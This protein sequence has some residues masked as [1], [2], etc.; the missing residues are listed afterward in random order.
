[1]GETMTE[2]AI[3]VYVRKD[4]EDRLAALKAG[5]SEIIEIFD[6]FVLA[7]ATEEEIEWCKRNNFKLEEKNEARKIKLRNVEFDTSEAEPEPHIP[8]RLSMS[9]AAIKGEDYYIV[10]FKGPI[11]DK[12]KEEV[13]KLG[14]KLFDYVPNYAFTVKMDPA[15]KQKVQNLTFVQWVGLYQ[16]AY[17][18][19]SRLVGKKK[20]IP[21]S[22][23]ESLS[24]DKTIAAVRPE[25]NINVLIH[26]PEDIQNISA[27]IENLGGTI[28]G[29]AR[30]KIRVAIDASAVEEIAKIT[31]VKWIEEYVMPE[32]HNDIAAGIM[33]VPEVW[34]ERPE[35]DGT[36]QIV[37]VADTGLDSGVNDTSMHADFRGRIKNVHSWPNTVPAEYC[38]NPGA[39]DGAAD[40]DGH[41]T[42]VAGSI[43]GN[44][45]RSNKVIKGIAYN[46]ELIFQAI[47]QWVDIKS[48]YEY[49]LSDGYYLTGIP[50]DLEKLFQ[51]AYD[52]GARIH[53]NSWGGDVAGVY[54]EEAGEVDEFVW[55]HK[56]MIIL[57]SAGNSGM[58]ANRDGKV[59]PDS[60]GSP[61]T[62]KNCITVGASENVR[63]HGGYQDSYGRLWQSD[64]PKNPIKSD[65]ISNNAEGM[66]AFSS[67]GPTDDGRI[68]PDI[69]AP[70][71]NILSTRSSKATGDGWGLYNQYY[72]YMG[73][74]SMACPL[75]AGAATL[76]RQYYTDIRAHV[77][78]SAALIKATLINGA[79]EM[80]GQY[81]PSEAGKVPN[82]DQGWGRVNIKESLFPELPKKIMFVDNCK[83]PNYSLSTGENK[84]FEYTVS[85][86]T[87]PMKITLVWTDYPGPS[88]VNQLNLVVT[89][90]GGKVYHGN[91][92]APPYDASFDET[93]NVECIHI[94]VPEFGT[95]TVEVIAKEIPQEKQDF[96][97]VVSGGFGEIIDCKEISLFEQI[98]DNLSASKDSKSYKVKVEGDVIGKKLIAHLKGPSGSD[99]DLYI[100]Y[101]SKPTTSDYDD[102]GFT[103]RSNESVIIESAQEGYYYIMVH[104]YHG[105]GSY[106]LNSIITH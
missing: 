91:Q 19:S 1:M 54:D 33:K 103:Y 87:I 85:E 29:K 26:E 97:L 44:G 14:G 51:Q 65:L 76:V 57:F 102:R 58:D 64:F 69:V 96:A 31:G 104:S 16:P 46:A 4:E 10:Q 38:N 2:K 77:E 22:E 39:D 47:E 24:I 49:D 90:P 71:T 15:T 92:F 95:Y 37:A 56:D 6:N 52:D 55:T 67:R 17:K 80:K 89:S 78:P 45:S 40:V 23:F 59:D 12:W 34:S 72:M 101:G 50:V 42:H 93:N 5:I 48:M 100:K 79:T 83:D 36:G 60:M 8:S 66:V 13:K 74:T 98:S 86:T 61:G 63:G 73:G 28:V 35:L 18:V 68:K 27:D 88:L 3:L 7:K 94:D 84:T 25:G 43:L 82:N 30:T 62:A 32:F 105:S 106:T 20:K 99:F 11:I 75:T 21:V 70:G 53:S 9:M 41:G 81:T